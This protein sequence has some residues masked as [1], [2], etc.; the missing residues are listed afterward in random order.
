MDINKKISRLKEDKEINIKKEMN[1]TNL[2][3]P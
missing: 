1:R 2:L 3:T